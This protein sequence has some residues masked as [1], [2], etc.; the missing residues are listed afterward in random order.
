MERF[1]Q[2]ESV[3]GLMT[4]QA[5]AKELGV[6]PSAVRW[7]VL[8]NRLPFYR[9]AGSSVDLVR[10]EDVRAVAANEGGGERD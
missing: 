2:L 8:R 10:L 3:G 5:A 4:I 6:T 7:R 1:E 9:L